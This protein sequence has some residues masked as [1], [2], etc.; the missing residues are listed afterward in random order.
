MQKVILYSIF[1][2]PLLLTLTSFADENVDDL[3][4]DHAKE[5]IKTKK[6]QS[7]LKKDMADK[8]RKTAQIIEEKARI[9]AENKS[10]KKELDELEKQADA[11]NQTLK[12]FQKALKEAQNQLDDAND[13]KKSLTKKIAKDENETDKVEH[14]RQ[15][16]FNETQRIKTEIGQLEGRAHTADEA[17]VSREEEYHA[18]SAELT[19]LKDLVKAK[20]DEVKKKEAVVKNLQG[21]VETG[22][23][24]IEKAKKEREDLK[25]RDTQ[26]EIEKNRLQARAIILKKQYQDI[27]SENETLRHPSK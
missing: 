23:E 27:V 4:K 6:Q 15:H 16:D 9:D 22:K 19:R 3:R 26:A 21:L 18:V 1:I 11:K 24:E 2:F 10:L 7:D 5:V 20:E 17:R 13:K 8:E 14:E 25:R 12:K